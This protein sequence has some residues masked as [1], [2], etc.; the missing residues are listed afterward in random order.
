LRFGRG[1]LSGVCF[2]LSEI[3]VEGAGGGFYRRA[4]VLEGVRSG[5]DGAGDTRQQVRQ[6]EGGPVAGDDGGGCAA[7]GGVGGG[8]GAHGGGHACGGHG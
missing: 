2:A 1:D 8:G 5:S 6:G 3:G 7:K 4:G